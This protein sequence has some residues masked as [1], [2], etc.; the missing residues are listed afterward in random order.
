MTAFAVCKTVRHAALYINQA[1]C[2]SQKPEGPAV[3][4]SK[5]KEKTVCQIVDG[6][7]TDYRWIDGTWNFGEFADGKGSTDWDAVGIWHHRPS[8][9]VFAMFIADWQPT[10]AFKSQ[11]S[12]AKSMNSSVCLEPCIL[13]SEIIHTEASDLH[14]FFF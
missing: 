12:P 14:G 7:F 6:K 5:S 11:S 13:L 8:G 1:V 9:I 4:S 10:L 3:S 2:M